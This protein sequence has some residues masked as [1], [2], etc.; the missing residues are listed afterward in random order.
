MTTAITLLQLSTGVST[1]DSIW[2]TR[3]T[4]TVSPTIRLTKNGSW[5]AREK[6]L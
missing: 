5:A 6:W 4:Q 1:W 3:D 2:M